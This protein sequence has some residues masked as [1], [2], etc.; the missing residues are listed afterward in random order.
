MKILFLSQIVP[1]PPHGGVLQR[2][3]NLIRQ[4]GQR[5]DVILLAFVHPDVLS[6]SATVEESRRELRKYCSNVE[7]FPLWPKKSPLVGK[8]GYVLGGFSRLPFS[9]LAHRSKAFGTSMSRLVN[10]ERID[11]IHYDTLALAQYR[12]IGRGIPSTLTHHN[13]ESLLM[14]RRAEKDG[15]RWARAYLAWQA[16]KIR[17][18]EAAECGGF[19]LN[20]VVSDLDGSTLRGIVPGI[21]TETIANGVDIEYFRPAGSES[22]DVPPVLVYTGGMNMFAN[23]DA[24]LYFL[25][26]MWPIVKQALPHAKFVAVGQDPPAAVLAY[27]KADPSVVVTGYVDDI[28]PLVGQASVYVVPLRVGGGTRLKVVDAMA[29]GKA[30]VST[31]IGAEGLRVTDGKDILLVDGPRE[32]AKATLS[33]LQD[34]GLRS[35]LGASAR[36]LAE[37]EYAWDIIGRKL[38]ATYESVAAA[39]GSASRG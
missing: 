31:R 11:L 20:I 8:L 15:R 33:A 32:F 14:H 28:R 35:R 26:E 1:Y 2:G 7:Y 4:L 16:R 25:R 9:V 19:D 21:R 13:V 24:V 18:Y 37:R 36:S 30:I 27:A 10:R 22:P 23:A 17:A 39:T 38:Q 6:S 29:M 34:A 5:N 12:R 3:Y